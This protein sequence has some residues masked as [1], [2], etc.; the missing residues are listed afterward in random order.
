MAEDEVGIDEETEGQ[1]GGG[2]SKPSMGRRAYR[3]LRR[4][5]SVLEENSWEPSNEATFLL[6]EA[7]ILVLMDLADALRGGEDGTE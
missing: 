4:A 5:R 7:N 2:K 6:Q 1:G 3:N